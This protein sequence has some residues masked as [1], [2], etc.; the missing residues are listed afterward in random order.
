MNAGP[1]LKALLLCVLLALACDRSSMNQARRDAGSMSQ[2]ADGPVLAGGWTD[3]GGALGMDALQA[4]SDTH[5]TVDGH[6]GGN[7]GRVDVAEVGAS[8][9]P[10]P[11]SGQDAKLCLNGNYSTPTY[12]PCCPIDVF[13]AGGQMQE[14]SCDPATWFECTPFDGSFCTCWCREGKVACGC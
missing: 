5:E 1:L 2:D 6:I 12:T 14:A 11:D 7:D 8:G 3:G 9:G 10:G 4:S 13:H